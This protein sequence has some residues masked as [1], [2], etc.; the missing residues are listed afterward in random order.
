MKELVWSGIDLFPDRKVFDFRPVMIDG[1]HHL[2]MVAPRDVDWRTCTDGAALVLN[3]SY[4]VVHEL[5][6]AEL[7]DKIDLHEFNILEDGRT[8]LLASNDGREIIPE[9]HIDWKGKIVDNFFT[10]VDLVTKEQ[11]FH[12]VAS[13]HVPLA[14]ST[15]PTPKPGDAHPNWDWL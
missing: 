5:T 14:E 8:A 13:D 12:W 9:H 6:S 4:D 11:M 10:E 7:G 15:N 2:A 1:K 3:A